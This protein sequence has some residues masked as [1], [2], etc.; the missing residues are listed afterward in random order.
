MPLWGGCAAGVYPSAGDRHA[1]ETFAK[2]IDPGVLTACLVL[3]TAVEVDCCFSESR[4]SIAFQVSS[5]EIQPVDH[6]LVQNILMSF[7][8]LS[9]LTGYCRGTS[10]APIRQ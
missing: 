7:W 8:S 10:T 4:L 6:Q 2:L 1:T 5:K 9:L 3:V